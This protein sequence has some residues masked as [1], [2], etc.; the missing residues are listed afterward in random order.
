VFPDVPICTQPFGFEL[1]T[2]PEM[3]PPEIRWPQGRLNLTHRCL[4]GGAPIAGLSGKKRSGGRCGP[5]GPWADVLACRPM[6]LPPKVSHVVFSGYAAQFFQFF[7][8][9]FRL[10]FAEPLGVPVHLIEFA[11]LLL[12]HSD[13][14]G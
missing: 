5:R 6:M 1:F 4:D 12:W 8:R 9:L 2:W 7:L 14:I 13:R 3:L 10:S 11:G